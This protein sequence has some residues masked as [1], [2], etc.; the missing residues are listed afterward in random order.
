VRFE[1]PDLEGFNCIGP[2]QGSFT[3][4]ARD[5]A[6]AYIDSKWSILPLIC[7]FVRPPNYLVPLLLYLL[8]GTLIRSDTLSKGFDVTSHT[9]SIDLAHIVF[10]TISRTSRLSRVAGVH[11]EMAIMVG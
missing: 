11:L 1:T 4:E 7:S 10:R 8:P 6:E 3:W 5:Q 9:P 2:I